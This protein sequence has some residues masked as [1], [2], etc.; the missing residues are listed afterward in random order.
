MT[1]GKTGKTLI[2]FESGR[3]LMINMKRALRY[4]RRFR[5]LP[6]FRRKSA[7]HAGRERAFLHYSR[8]SLKPFLILAGG[9]RV[10]FSACSAKRLPGVSETGSTR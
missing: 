3:T 1:R 9:Q 2:H 7:E 4:T 5:I 10:I 6:L 8:K